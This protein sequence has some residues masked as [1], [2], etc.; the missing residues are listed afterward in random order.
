MYKLYTTIFSIFTFLTANNIYAQESYDLTDCLLYTLNSSPKLRS[1]RLAQEKEATTIM[2]QKSAFLPHIDAFV[3]YN[4][5]FNDLP[6]YVFPQA[7]GS[8]L[9]GESLSG[10]YPLQLGL[11]HNLNTGLEINQ[12]IFDMKF[13]GN[14]A[15][16]QHYQTYNDIKLSIAEEEVLY[17]VAT[18]FYQVALNEERLDFL[19]MNL[20]RLHKLQDI[21][22]LQADQGFARQSDY[23]KLLVKTSNLQSNKNKLQSGIKQQTRYLKL[24]MGM[25]QE[26][27][28]DLD[29]DQNHLMVAD[30]ESGEKTELLEQ[31]LLKE[32][33]ELHLLNARKLNSDYYPRL[34]AYAAFLFQAQRQQFNFF[35][36][37]QDWYNIHQWGLKLSIPIMRGFERKTKKQLSE[38]VDEQLAFGLEQ[39]QIQ[40]EVDYQNAKS[41]LEAA[42]MDQE[43]QRENVALAERVYKQSE[44]SYEQGTTLLMDFLD[45]EAT[46]R[47]AKMLYATAVLDTRLAEL[48][49]LKS[50]GKLKELI[51]R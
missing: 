36:S 17:Q 5:Y 24:L 23:N 16:Q 1:E 6:T 21:V 22:K 3:H 15:L 51:N 8:I 19:N 34:Q 45:S 41:E 29:F 46:L 33:Q 43:A 48:K 11:P 13:F 25:D 50:S 30:L 7:E 4:N 28:L 2:E 32:R 27:S 26:E 18:L 40:G 12:T 9:A 47:E 10:P 49:I 31:Q 35:A 14:E 37:N 42:R 38:I 20:D 39:K 44:L